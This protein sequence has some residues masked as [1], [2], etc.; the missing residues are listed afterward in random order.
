MWVDWEALDRGAA[1]LLMRAGPL[2]RGSSWSL[3]S[4]VLGYTPLRRATSR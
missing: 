1:V 2:Q 3:K 4:L